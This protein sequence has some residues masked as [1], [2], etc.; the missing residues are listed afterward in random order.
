[1]VV[2]VATLFA[3]R[4]G[5]S[6][7]LTAVVMTQAAQFA[8][9]NRQLVKY[10]EMHRHEIMFLNSANFRVAAQL[11]LDF[12]SVERVIEYLE[13]PQE[14]PAIIQTARPPAYWP[15]SSGELV[16]DGLVVQYAPHLPPALKD[17][18]FI[19]KPTEK[20][21]VVSC[22]FV[23]VLFVRPK[24][25]GLSIQIGRTGSGESVFLFL[26]YSNS[27]DKPS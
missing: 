26:H 13:V 8:E 11:E 19:V 14:A 3:L 22:T 9:A 18:S 27:P 2:F 5:I 12:N 17:M 10:V 6:N 15:S 16:V 23:V 7:G 1:M 25:L 24:N 21:G 4:G 20:V